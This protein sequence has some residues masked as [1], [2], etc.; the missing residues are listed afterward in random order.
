[1]DDNQNAT[2]APEQSSQPAADP[3]EARRIEITKD[4]SWYAGSPKYDAARHRALVKEMQSLG[5]TP[6]PAAPVKQQEPPTYTVPAEVEKQLAALNDPTNENG[7]WSKDPVKQ[8]AAVVELNRMM[9]AAASDEEREAIAGAPVE[10]LRERFGVQEQR[11]PQHL[12]ASWS[13]ESE[14]MVLGTLAVSGAPAEG[15]RALHKEYIGM[16]TNA[17]GD[18]AHLDVPSMVDNFR[19]LGTK[20]GIDGKVMDGL[21]DHEL[22]RLGLK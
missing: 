15:V 3:I 9:M 18:P 22:K 14:A 19:K 8:K 16:L 2:P 21:I 11:V 4:E 17:M 20:H 13:T 12:A 7:I 1:M 10:T 6:A 5:C